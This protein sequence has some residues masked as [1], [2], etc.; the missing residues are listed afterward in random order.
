MADAD[1]YPE[2]YYPDA[3]GDFIF[4]KPGWSDELTSQHGDEGEAGTPNNSRPK[5][6][7]E[8]SMNV[9][10]SYF[11]LRSLA[12]RARQHEKSALT[13]SSREVSAIEFAYD[14]LQTLTTNQDIGPE[15]EYE[16][17]DDEKFTTPQKLDFDPF[18]I[19]DDDDYD[20]ISCVF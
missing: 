4:E 10:E 12:E 18:N 17:H 15:Y 11:L 20:E 8:E 14:Q 1:E 7:T 6:L 16:D 5:R 19:G 3:N 9:L 2:L 13:L